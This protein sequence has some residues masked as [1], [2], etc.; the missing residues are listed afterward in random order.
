MQPRLKHALLDRA[1][2]FFCS[3]FHWLELNLPRS[4]EESKPIQQ[5]TPGSRVA[6]SGTHPA[7]ERATER[8]PPRRRACGRQS[9]LPGLEPVHWGQQWPWASSLHVWVP[10]SPSVHRTDGSRAHFRGRPGCYLQHSQKAA[11]STAPAKSPSSVWLPLGSGSMSFPGFLKH[12]QGAHATKQ[13]ACHPQPDTQA[14]LCVHSVLRGLF[15]TDLCRDRELRARDLSSLAPHTVQGDTANLCTIG[16]C[17]RHG[18]P[19]P[20]TVKNWTPG[21]AGLRNEDPFASLHLDGCVR[22]LF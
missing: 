21:P 4:G 19:G 6:L 20:G 11:W 16:V 13:P 10:G 8:W 15:L 5:A 3:C 9:R 22:L 18:A 2:R 1:N 12:K 14:F 17:K 7:P